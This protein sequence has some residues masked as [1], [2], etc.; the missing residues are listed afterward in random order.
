MDRQLLTNITYNRGSLCHLHFSTRNTLH[1]LVILYSSIPHISIK[2]CMDLRSP[3]TLIVYKGGIWIARGVV[4]KQI[5]HP[6]TLTVV[7]NTSRPKA[8]IVW[9][10]DH[11]TSLWL[12]HCDVTLGCHVH[13]NTSVGTDPV[14]DLT[15]TK[16]WSQLV[17][18]AVLVFVCVW[19]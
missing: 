5:T 10:V 2:R 1:T 19:F 3:C 13:E 16:F 11:I 6:P 18:I 14:E 8:T 9:T 12:C 17:P 15:S 7:A 4:Y